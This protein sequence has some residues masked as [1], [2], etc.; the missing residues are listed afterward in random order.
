MKETVPLGFTGETFPPGIHMCYIYNDEDERRRIIF[1]FLESG[2][3]NGEKVSYFMDANTADTMKECQ[4]ALDVDKL[5]EEQQGHFSVATTR[6]AYCPTGIFVPDEML[7]RLSA[8]YTRSVTEG[9]AG[10]RVA[11]EMSW[12]VREVP[13]SFR[14]ME[15][16]AR[17]NT[18]LMHYP[19]T[20]I[21]QYDARCFDGR[22]L[23]DVL[24]VH[25][26]IILHGQILKNPYYVQSWW[27]LKR[28][29]ALHE[30][31]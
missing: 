15:Y 12:A 7:D 20:A 30:E 27:L 18:A 1:Q 2:L 5:F 16:E 24:A 6:E 10:A 19:V 14:L 8:F 9:Y 23:R 3:R 13:G 25:P 17:I 22:M 4:S 28:H 31:H 29:L 11:G 21:C 26:M